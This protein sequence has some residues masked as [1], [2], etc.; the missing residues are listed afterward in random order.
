MKVVGESIVNYEVLAKVVGRSSE[1][2][3]KVVGEVVGGLCLNYVLKPKSFPR[4]GSLE[5]ESHPTEISWHDHPE[6]L[7]MSCEMSCECHANVM[8]MSC[9]S[10]VLIYV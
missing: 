9:E 8:R 4:T 10:Y 6:P 3:R 7:H 1:G 2:R 5:S